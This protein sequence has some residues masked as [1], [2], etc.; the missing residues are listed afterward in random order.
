MKQQGMKCSKRESETTPKATAKEHKT[1]ANVSKNAAKG[2]EQVPCR[3]LLLR[4]T[5]LLY[6]HG[7]PTNSTSKTQK[8]IPSHSRNFSNPKDQI[9]IK[10]AAKKF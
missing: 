2:I 10:I 1:S 3:G 7:V 9:F 8:G 6:I 5:L 4:R